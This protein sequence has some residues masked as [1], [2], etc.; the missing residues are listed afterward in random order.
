MAR[1]QTQTTPPRTV[2]IEV[3]GTTY[4]DHYTV[5]AGIMTVSTGL[6]SK[7]AQVSGHQHDSLARLLLRELVSESKA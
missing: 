6:G 7:P 3:N 2:T 4:M 1:E 5:S